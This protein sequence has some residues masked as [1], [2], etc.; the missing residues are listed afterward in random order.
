MDTTSLIDLCRL[1]LAPDE[2]DVP[3]FEEE[4]TDND[5]YG[6]ISLCLPIKVSSC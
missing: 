1:C 5:L 3:I 4:K 2:V 6:K